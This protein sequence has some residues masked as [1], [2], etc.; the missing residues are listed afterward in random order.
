MEGWRRKFKAPREHSGP[1]RHS[2]VTP[3]FYVCSLN[4]T[5]TLQPPITDTNQFIRQLVTVTY[6]AYSNRYRAIM[7]PFLWALRLVHAFE[8]YS[9]HFGQTF[10]M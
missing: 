4:Q 9:F 10:C 3:D 8:V 5:R 7:S 2:R 1:K 6:Q